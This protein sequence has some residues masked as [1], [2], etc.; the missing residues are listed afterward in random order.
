MIS[1]V[2]GGVRPTV[3][4]AS[5]VK[6]IVDLAAS[7][8]LTWRRH[9][10]SACAPPARRWCPFETTLFLITRMAPTAGFGLVLPKPFLASP[11]AMRI[12]RSSISVGAI[13]H[14]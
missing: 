4:H 14:E 7:V 3:E 9:S 13:E 2:H 5:S 8:R 6:Y 1:L 11:S 10:T 12:N